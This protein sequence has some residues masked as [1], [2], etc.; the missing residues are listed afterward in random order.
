MSAEGVD[1][2]VEG[3]EEEDPCG[4]SSVG[5]LGLRIGSLFIILVRPKLFPKSARKGH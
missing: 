4:P 1:P 3:G 5:K 2:V